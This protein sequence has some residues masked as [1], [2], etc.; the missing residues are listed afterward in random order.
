VVPQPI[1]RFKRIG[2]GFLKDLPDS[3]LARAGR[4]N[5]ARSSSNEALH[6]QESEEPYY[7]LR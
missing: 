7:T 2:F 3:G 4:P 6:A 1:K 5:T